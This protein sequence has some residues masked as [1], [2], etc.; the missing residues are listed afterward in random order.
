MADVNVLICPQ[1]DTKWIRSVESCPAKELANL[2][3]LW[4]HVFVQ[5]SIKVVLRDEGLFYQALV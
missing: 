1:L 4:D 2:F 3:A 5:V